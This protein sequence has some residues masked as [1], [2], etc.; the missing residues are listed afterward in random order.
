MI[1]V[2]TNLLVYAHRRESR[3]HETAYKVMQGLSEGERFWAIPWPCCYEFFSVV[4]NRRIW[5]EAATQPA[6]AW[7]Q[8]E[9]W[10]SSP[11]NQL[12]GE[13][14]DFLKVLHGFIQRPRVYGAV[15][16]DA[17]VAAICVAHGVEMLLTRDRDFSLFPELPTHDPIDSPQVI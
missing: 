13:T 1:A 5:K 8:L 10:T 14:G 16:H 4:T 2:D 12:I 3:F 6:R 15:V 7:A 17:R 11:S 9:A